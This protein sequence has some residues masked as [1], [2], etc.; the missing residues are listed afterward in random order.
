MK[1]TSYGKNQI[2]ETNAV[3]RGHNNEGRDTTSS[4]YYYVQ[5]EAAITN[6]N[7]M[8]RNCTMTYVAAEFDIRPALVRKK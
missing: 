8:K 6:K 1:Q 7:E 2:K 3:Y 4:S 5:A